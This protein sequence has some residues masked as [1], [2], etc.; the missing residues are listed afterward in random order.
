[1]RPLRRLPAHEK[2]LCHGKE[3]LPE[4]AVANFATTVA[5]EKNCERLKQDDSSGYFAGWYFQA[6]LE[7]SSRISPR[8]SAGSRSSVSSLMESTQHFT[9]CRSGVFRV[10]SGP[11]IADTL[12]IADSQPPHWWLLNDHHHILQTY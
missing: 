6:S 3:A 8:R 9:S 1:M 4:A 11:F 10:M 5:D 2:H 12:R 7:Y